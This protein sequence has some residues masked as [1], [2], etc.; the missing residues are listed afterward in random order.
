[1]FIPTLI[2][3]GSKEQQAKWVPKAQKLEIIGVYAQTELGHGSFVRGIETTATYDPETQHFIL[4]SPTLTSTK[5][6]AGGKR[7]SPTFYHRPVG[8]LL[9][10]HMVT[11]WVPSTWKGLTKSMCTTCI[12][13]H[14]CCV[15]LTVQYDE[16][17]PC[18]I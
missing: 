5:W 2:A 3:Q 4:H 17:M 7:I 11:S 14:V 13:C 9:Q 12:S 6:W 1:M 15:I 10:H 18:A 8:V 16:K